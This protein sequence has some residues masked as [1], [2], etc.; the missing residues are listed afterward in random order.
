MLCHSLRSMVC[1][2]KGKLYLFSFLLCEHEERGETFLFIRKIPFRIL[3][4]GKRVKVDF[5]F[6]FVLKG[7]HEWKNDPTKYIKTQLTNFLTADVPQV[8]NLFLFHLSFS[9]PPSHN[10]EAFH[11]LLNVSPSIMLFCCAHRKTRRTSLLL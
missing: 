2:I 7:K 8:G 9:R 3:S 1:H 4:H 11:F 6:L 5:L 10:R